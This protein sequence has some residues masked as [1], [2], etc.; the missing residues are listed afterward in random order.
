M[1][2][3]AVH[4]N[5][6]AWVE[7]N[8]EALTSGEARALFVFGNAIFATAGE[9]FFVFLFETADSQLSRR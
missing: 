2:D 1:S 4:L 3:E 9:R 6:A 8:I 5:K 7:Q